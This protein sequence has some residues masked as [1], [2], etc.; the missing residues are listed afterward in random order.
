MGKIVHISL[1]NA[2]FFGYHGFY[3]EEQLIGNEFFLSIITQY[4]FTET[5]TEELGNT[6]NYEAL[7]EIAKQA[8]AIPKKLLETVA[9][10]ILDEI[11]NRFPDIIHIKVEII[12]VNPPFGG[13]RAHAKVSLHWTN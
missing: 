1:E 8:M 5:Q 6:V 12:K 7:Y 10:T 9:H 3:P 11:R 2:R 4:H 13:D